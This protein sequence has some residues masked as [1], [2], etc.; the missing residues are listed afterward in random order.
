MPGYLDGTSN[1]LKQRL[2]GAFHWAKDRFLDLLERR[3]AFEHLHGPE[4]VPV[5][6]D[7]ALLLCLVRDGELW[8]DAF[9]RHHLDLGV[10]HLFFLDNGSTDS[11]V[12]RI[13]ACDR[14]SAW[15]T[16]LSFGRFEIAMRRWLARRVGRGSWCLICDVDELFD[17]PHSDALPLRSFLGYLNGRSYQVVAAQMLDMF[18]ELPFDELD[19]RPG[20]RLRQKYRY[21][22]LSGIRRRRD[23][24]WIDEEAPEHTELFCTFGGI[25]ERV[26]GSRSL[27][28]TKHP[29]VRYGPDVRVL[30]YDGHFSVGRVADVTGVLL[31]YK[32]LSNLYE[33]ALQAV[34]EGQHSR[35]SHHYRRFLEVLERDPDLSL[36][37]PGSRELESASQLLDEGL[38][39]ASEDYES[40][41][42]AHRATASL[43]D[44]AAADRTSAPR[45]AEPGAVGARESDA[46]TADVA[47]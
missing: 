5:G 19:S 2:Y 47:G 11:T 9:I 40:W 27:L 15:R 14:A 1:R 38:L 4:E 34:R 41:V 46:G 13:R 36:H 16:E 17:Y 39:T 33:Y 26:F 35:G 21:Y 12:D 6:D 42:E 37:G 29:L 45:G 31:H 43:T 44:G 25:R 3:G 24:F 18:S 32:F 7:E 10:R 22:D 20:D 28:Q 23:I 8:I 30:P